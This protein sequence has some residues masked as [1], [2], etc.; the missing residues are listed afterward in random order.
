M[1]FRINLFNESNHRGHKTD[2]G[3]EISGFEVFTFENSYIA[4]EYTK[5][6]KKDELKIACYTRDD[7][8]VLW[9]TY[10]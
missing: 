3:G 10:Y 7:L 2:L 6:F 4:N 9:Q 5:K 1:K 8:I